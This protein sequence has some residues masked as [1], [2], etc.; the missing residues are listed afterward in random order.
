M[1]TLHIDHDFAKGYCEKKE[2]AFLY[3]QASRAKIQGKRKKMFCRK[4]ELL[5]EH[6]EEHFNSGGKGTAKIIKGDQTT[7]AMESQA[8]HFVEIRRGEIISEKPLIV[9]LKS[10]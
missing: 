5:R 9:S 4:P 10:E 7:F 1:A 2:C 3:T 6:L 8:R